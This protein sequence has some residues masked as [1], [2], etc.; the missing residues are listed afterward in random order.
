M[1]KITIVEENTVLR[2]WY[3][4]YGFIHT[5]VRAYPDLPFTVGHM[6]FCL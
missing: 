6:E 5:G 2:P 1:I 3:E 4:K